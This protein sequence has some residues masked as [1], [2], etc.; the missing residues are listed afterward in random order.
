MGSGKQQ[1][2]QTLSGLGLLETIATTCW[3]RTHAYV[4]E[5]VQATLR[6]ALENRGHISDKDQETLTQH[7]AA[8]LQALHAAHEEELTSLL[9]PARHALPAVDQIVLSCGL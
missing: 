2:E 6:V 4:R 9:A 5:I 1:I 7:V 8:I 3:P